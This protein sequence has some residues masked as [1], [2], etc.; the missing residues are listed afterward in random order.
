METFQQFANFAE[1]YNQYFLVTLSI[2]VPGGSYF[3]GFLIEARAQENPNGGA[4]GSFSLVN[5]GISQLLTCANI[6]VRSSSI[7]L[8]C[9][10]G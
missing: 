10:K 4:V 9:L 2:A 1:F 6:K 8:L 3:K 7:I 5:P